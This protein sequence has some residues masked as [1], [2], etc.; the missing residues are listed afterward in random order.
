MLQ[1]LEQHIAASASVAISVHQMRSVFFRGGP[2]HPF[3]RISLCSVTVAVTQHAAVSACEYCSS[4]SPTTKAHCTFFITLC[5]LA[6]VSR[7]AAAMLIPRA[8]SMA[9]LK[10]ILSQATARVPRPP[11]PSLLPTT[12]SKK[13]TTFFKPYTLAV[14]FQRASFHP[15]TRARGRFIDPAYAKEDEDIA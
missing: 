4:A 9:Q 15:T 8:S 2:R 5:K 13:L 1:V 10:R 11:L 6:P 3:R 12:H 14:R 7:E